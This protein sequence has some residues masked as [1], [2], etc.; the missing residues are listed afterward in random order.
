MSYP[1][2]GPRHQARR[3]VYVILGYHQSV[4]AYVTS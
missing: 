4:D 1:D 2:A 3:A